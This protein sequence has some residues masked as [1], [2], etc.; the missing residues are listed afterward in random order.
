MK[1]SERMSQSINPMDAENK[2][3]GEVVVLERQVEALLNLIR[4]RMQRES[5]YYDGENTLVHPEC[6]WC[7]EDLP[8]HHP[9]CPAQA[10]LKEM[11]E[12]G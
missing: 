8:E 12:K 9:N 4:P 6:A 7:F 1:L 11:G 3:V 10:L 2:W 5:P